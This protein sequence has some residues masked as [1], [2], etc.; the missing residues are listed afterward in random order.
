MA[1]EP[2]LTRLEPDH[3]PAS[4][5]I[6][7]VRLSPPLSYESKVGSNRPS[8]RVEVASIVCLVLLMMLTGGW[9][10]GAIIA[11]VVNWR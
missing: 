4:P 5:D 11:I 1:Q 6:P 2:D 8:K 7:D 9:L 10:L 3:A